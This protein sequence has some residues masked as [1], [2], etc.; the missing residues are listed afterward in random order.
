MKTVVSQSG[1]FTDCDQWCEAAAGWNLHFQQLDGGNLDAVMNR[2]LTPDLA[3]QHVSLSRRFHQSGVAPDGLFTFGVPGNHRQVR[4]FDRRRS[5]TGIMNFNRSN[6]FDC[7]SEPGFTAHTF[8]VLSSSYLE[9][10]RALGATDGEL[11]TLERNG[12]LAVPDTEYE[13]LAQMGAAIIRCGAADGPQA[14]GAHELAADIRYLLAMALIGADDA[15]GLQDRVLRRR[16]VDR[17]LETIHASNGQISVPEV[18]TYASVSARSLSRG[19]QE[20]FGLST[21]QYMVA[22]RLSAAR[23]K[24]LDG[25]TVTEA[26][27]EYGFWH[28]GRFSA[29]YKAMFGELPSETLA[30]S[31][32]KQA[33]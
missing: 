17:A 28:L 20:R 7:V 11:T 33:G 29:D 1:R 16:A 5:Q 32:T 22:T 8:S 26:A 4:W 10:C 6:G 23:R 2:A 9:N 31:A 14:S 27:S 19:F 30:V 18:C 15:G 24:L 13:R 3:V 12:M 25:V 21:K